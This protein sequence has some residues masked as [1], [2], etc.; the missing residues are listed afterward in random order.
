M[1]VIKPT[2]LASLISSIL[3]S[4]VLH[5]ATTLDMAIVIDESGSMSGEHNAFIGTYVRNLDSMLKD[6]NVTLNQYGL[7]GFGGATYTSPSANEAGRENGADFYRHFNLSLDPDNV[8]GT[9]DEFHAITSELVTTGGTEDGYRAIDYTFRNFDF[10][11]TAGSSIMLIT[12]EDRDNDRTNLDTS[13]LPSGM[14]EIDKAYVQ[15]QLAQYNTVVHAV[16]SQRFTDLDGNPA[17]A[18]VG[19]DPATGYAYVKDASGVITK[20][21]GYILQSADGT[22]QA[23]Y[24]ELALASGG[25]AM[26]I[27]GLRS[28]Y[29]DADALAALSG[30]LAK[31]VADISA[32]QTPVVGIDC[33]AAT[34]VAAQICGAIAASNNT[35]L[36]QVGQQISKPEQYRQLSQYQVSQMLRTAAANSRQ[37]RRVVLDRLSDL[38]RAGMASN[39][40]HLMNYSNANVNLSPDM[41]DS[42]RT[43]RGGA[44]SGDQGDVGYFIRGIYTRGDYDNTS[45]ALGYDSTTYTIVAGVD[46]YL[47]DALQMGVALNYSTTDSDFSGVRGGTDADTWGATLYGSLEM[48][49]ELHLEGNL[50]YSRAD[51]DT[52]RDSGF[53]MLDG[54]TEGDI[55]NLSVGVIK[56]MQ[57]R[58]LAVQPFAY[59]HYTDVEIDGFTEQGGATA[60]RVGNSDI[61]SLVSELGFSTA[62]QFSDSL[63]GDLRLA[64]EHEF[65]DDGTSVRTAFVAAPGNVFDSRT[66][67]QSSDYGRIGLGLTKDMGI[68]RTLAL[69]AETL[70]GHNNYD[71]HSFEV[72]FRQN[73]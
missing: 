63:T 54:D 28:V 16:V 61:Q 9:A 65:E 70:V 51:F 57:V 52:S 46:R 23:D 69:R 34:G 21:Q 47:S 55:W 62:M 72:R 10:R 12:D 32:G 3:T 44:A 8:W 45:A 50:S 73:F 11:P 25:T 5:A 13:H 6:Q 42:M 41:V 40:I 48:A 36:Q 38:R 26:D 58:N 1:K 14:T 33:N 22:T 59:L 67:S 31:L 2:L 68:N 56:S 30:E 35:G 20:V 27:D 71:E 43:A 39:D 66:P 4:G 18:I 29:T 53:G 7:V 37:V 15:A 64:W 19:A 17:I 24:T 49:P 60:L